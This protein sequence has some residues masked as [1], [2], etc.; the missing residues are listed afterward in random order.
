MIEPKILNQ[1]TDDLIAGCIRADRL[2]QKQLYERYYG[3]MMVVC[4]RFARDEDEAVGMLNEGFL[5]VFDKLEQF[6]P[7][8]S[9]ES[10]I[11]RI[12]INNAIDHYRKTKKHSHVIDIDHA[13]GSFNDED[14]LPNMT[15]DEIIL[16]IQKLPISY[17]TVFNLFVLE[18]LSH[19]EIGEKLQ[20]TEGSS[21]SNLA[22]AR[23]KL[24]VL[25]KK[26]YIN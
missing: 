23:K 19:K 6:R 5:K 14:I 2:A 20:I 17:R 22:K 8:S 13:S 7:E 9:L 12:M 15:A 4:M 1:S 18:G 10:W 3:K 16:L 26:F 21:K 25:I 24:Q 11:R